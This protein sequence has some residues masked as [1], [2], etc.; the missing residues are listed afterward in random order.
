MDTKLVMIA[1]NQF[2]LPV[3]FVAGMT[4]TEGQ[5]KALN[6]TY[7]EN[8]RNNW[9]SKVKELGE[10]PAPGDLRDMA[11][12]I[13]EYANEYEF[14]VA[15]T[16][17]ASVDPVEREA[18]AIAKEFIKGKLA[19][20]GLTFKKG[21]EGMDADTWA[22]KIN[23]NIEKVASSEEVLKMARKRLEAKKKGIEALA[24]GLDLS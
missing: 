23:A 18:T 15:G 16:P 21:P 2:T 10:S 1:G 20:R 13:T 8:I 24:A 3:P 4:L 7:H 6:Q 22:D 9:A 12:R 5:A 19:E 14:P 17:R 11:A